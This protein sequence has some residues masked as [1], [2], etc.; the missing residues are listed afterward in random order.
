MKASEFI[1]EMPQTFSTYKPNELHNKENNHELYLQFSRMPNKDELF[2]LSA[3]S[4]VYI[5]SK[6]IYCLDS[7]IQ[8]VTYDMEFNTKTDPL[9]GTFVWQASVWHSKIDP[10]TT[11]L[12]DKV[13]FEYLIPTYGTVLT[14]SRQSWD[15]ARYWMGLIPKAF[16]KGLQV[17]YV[18]FEK[19]TTQHIPDVGY[20]K[21]FYAKMGDIIWTPAKVG[22]MRRMTITTKS[23]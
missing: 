12:P 16:D 10:I 20:W 5:H 8:R 11:G 14:D 18:D 13:F 7:S 17:Y 2:S 21:S 15:G 19:R 1:N 6:E 9:I 23:L 22:K 3:T 4:K